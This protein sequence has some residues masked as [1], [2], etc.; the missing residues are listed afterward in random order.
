MNLARPTVTPKFVEYAINYALKSS[1]QEW[2]D[3]LE[4][5]DPNPIQIPT[6]QRKIVWDEDT[7]E[8]FLD[9]KAVI[10]G[11]V[12]LAK[13]PYDEPLVLLDGLQRF[14]TSTAILHYLHTVILPNTVAPDE[15]CFRI[16]VASTQGAESIIAHNHNELKNNSRRG[17][18]DSYNQLYDNV[19]SVMDKL[20]KESIEK[21]AEKLIQTF[22]TWK[23]SINLP[24]LPHFLPAMPSLSKSVFS[25][26]PHLLV[27]DYVVESSILKHQK[28]ILVCSMLWQIG[29][30]CQK[31]PSTKTANFNLLLDMSGVP[32]SVPS[33]ILYLRPAFHSILRTAS[34][35]FVFF[36]LILDIIRLRV[37]TETMSA[38]PRSRERVVL[39]CR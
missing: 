24:H 3:E 29:H 17:I 2:S 9:S 5:L 10:F 30:P 38:T 4:G 35:G 22:N 16:L 34:S 37:T 15:E 31:H 36:D 13:S 28:S 7:I 6:Y 1:G 14:A 26:L 21:L 39:V 12:I 23:G 18:Q 8:N 27:P 11:T 32:G 33:C 20:K 25:L 19:R